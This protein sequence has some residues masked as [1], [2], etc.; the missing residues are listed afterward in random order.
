MSDWKQL[1]R[2]RGLDLT[3]DDIGRIAGS[4]DALE[5]SWRSLLDK[6]PYDAE[7]AVI[8]QCLPAA[9]EERE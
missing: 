3:D 9:G 6:L 4:L 1:A 7:P 2:A 5:A 8:M